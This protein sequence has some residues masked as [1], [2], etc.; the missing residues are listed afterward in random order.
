M[1]K[2]DYSVAKIGVDTAKNELFQEV[3]DRRR[4]CRG[5]LLRWED[6]VR[7]GGQ[8]HDGDARGPRHPAENLREAVEVPAAARGGHAHL[9]AVHGGDAVGLGCRKESSIRRQ[10]DEE[11]LTIMF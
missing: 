2:N 4:L 8:L 1:L 5:S 10:N 11:V 6:L 3:T 7:P 9:A